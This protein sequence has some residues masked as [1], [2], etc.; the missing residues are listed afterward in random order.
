MS[1]ASE[2]WPRMAVIWFDLTKAKAV[3]SRSP[4]C[5]MTSSWFTSEGG[6][7]NIWCP[8]KSGHYRKTR[9]RSEILFR[10]CSWKQSGL[11]WE[12]LLCSSSLLSSFL[13]LLSWKTELLHQKNWSMKGCATSTL[14]HALVWC[15]DTLPHKEAFASLVWL[16]TGALFNSPWHDVICGCWGFKSSAHSITYVCVWVVSWVQINNKDVHQERSVVWMVTQVQKNGE[17]GFVA[18]CQRMFLSWLLLRWVTSEFD[19]SFYWVWVELM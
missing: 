1:S 5:S 10:P 2:P 13:S 18:Q 15:Q 17:N 8:W 9:Q 16:K 11:D 12:T 19:L 7:G 4:G 3:L 14:I 6:G